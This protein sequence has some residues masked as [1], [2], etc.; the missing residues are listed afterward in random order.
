MSENNSL[1]YSG[2]LSKGV[3]YPARCAS[4]YICRNVLPSAVGASNFATYLIYS[5]NLPNSLKKN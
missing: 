1:L 2:I 3:A 5:F 4:K